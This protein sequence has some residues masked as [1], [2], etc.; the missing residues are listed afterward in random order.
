MGLGA[1]FVFTGAMGM[2]RMPDFFTRI[3]PAGVAESLGVPLILLGIMLQSGLTLYTG[4]L[5]LLLVFLMIAGP[6]ATHVVSK[7]AVICGLQPKK[8]IPKK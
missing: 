7:T 1:F 5:F 3:H 4:K 8:R 6:T 2:L